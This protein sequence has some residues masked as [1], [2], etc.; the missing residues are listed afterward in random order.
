MAVFHTL[1]P[2]A[3]G[4]KNSG[5]LSLTPNASSC[6]RTSFKCNGTLTQ[7]QNYNREQ[8]LMIDFSLLNYTYVA[9]T[10]QKSNMISLSP[11]V[12]FLTWKN[13]RAD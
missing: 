5:S 6:I 3:M 4:V 9:E 13:F 11:T 7:I 1:N 2:K 8:T 10:S 12:C